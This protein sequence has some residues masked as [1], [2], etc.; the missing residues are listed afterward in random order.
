MN[1]DSDVDIRKL[2]MQMK[3]ELHSVVYTAV[4]VGGIYGFCVSLALSNMTEVKR[5]SLIVLGC[6]FG[7]YI[8][9]LRKQDLYEKSLM[10]YSQLDLLDVGRKPIPATTPAPAEQAAKAVEAVAIPAEPNLPNIPS[11]AVPAD[12]KEVLKAGKGKP[13]T[14]TVAEPANSPATENA[15]KKVT[16]VKKKSKA[17]A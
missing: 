4:A 12:V 16:T 8:G 3:E 6:I 11:E 9:K 13:K 17:Q 5:L 2:Y 1:K 14:E 15:T 7:Y 10:I